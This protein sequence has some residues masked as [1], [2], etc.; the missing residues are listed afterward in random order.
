[1]STISPRAPRT[2]K[3]RRANPSTHNAGEPLGRYTDPGGRERAL[4]ALPR[5]QARVRR[6]RGRLRLVRSDRRAGLEPDASS[7]GVSERLAFAH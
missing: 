7:V 2:L 6:Q 1:M 3:T 5:K 4:V